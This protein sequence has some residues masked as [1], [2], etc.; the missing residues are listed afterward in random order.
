[1]SHNELFIWRFL[2]GGGATERNRRDSS[3]APNA[4][5]RNTSLEIE[6]LPHCIPNSILTSVDD[7]KLSAQKKSTTCHMYMQS[8]L[9]VKL[10]L[11]KTF[12]ATALHFLSI[13]Y[14]CNR[15][16]ASV[17][18]PNVGI[19]GCVHVLVGGIIKHETWR[20]DA[21]YHVIS[22]DQSSTRMIG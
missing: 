16:D 10:S 11:H 18:T 4:M 7:Y 19:L 15:D 12:L 17:R 2:E 13:L 1:M 6:E 8:L 14:Y 21:G 22:L 5:W 3:C 20:D 9:H